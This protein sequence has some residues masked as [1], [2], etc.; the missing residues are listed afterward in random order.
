MTKSPQSATKLRLSRIIRSLVFLGCL[1]LVFLAGAA[2]DFPMPGFLASEEQPREMAG[3]AEYSAPVSAEAVAPVPESP[4]NSV[5]AAEDL[6]VGSAAAELA[7]AAKPRRVNDARQTALPTPLVPATQISPFAH[8]G[9]A[10]INS[11]LPE[12]PAL[13]APLARAGVIV[14]EVVATAKTP[15]DSSIWD[16]LTIDSLPIPGLGSA[17]VAHAASL[18]MPV[19]N[20]PMQPSPFAPAEQIAPLTAP[21]VAPQ[22]GGIPTAVGP[23]GAPIPPRYD[24]RTPGMLPAMPRTPSAPA[25][26]IPARGT[27]LDHNTQA[28]ELARQQQDILMLRQQ[29]DQRMQDLQT[30]E[31]KMKDMLKEA[32]EIEDKKVKSLVQMYANMKPRMAAQALE[33]MDERIAVRILGGMAP[34]QSGEILT[35]TNPAKTAKFTEMITRMRMGD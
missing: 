35:Y 11:A 9:S 18:D 23:D 19:P 15:A 27:S 20:A 28:Q 8:E 14:P 1:K 12:P 7:A 2:F 21:G 32:K 5:A 22:P 3:G 29:M 4:T 24:G 17:R 34:K 33:N 25:P 16:S 31:E 30:A 26:Q 10:F 6:P 13:D